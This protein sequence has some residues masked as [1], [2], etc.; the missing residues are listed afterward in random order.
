M[1]C[2]RIK[3]IEEIRDVQ[4]EPWIIREWIRERA[5]APPPADTTT[6]WGYT[7]ATVATTDVAE[8]NAGG[9]IDEH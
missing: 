9:Q 3:F 2:K 7:T 5:G 6:T 1:R 4:D 8:F